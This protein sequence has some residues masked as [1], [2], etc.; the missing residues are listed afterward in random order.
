M[1]QRGRGIRSVIVM[2][3]DHNTFDA[4]A[5]ALAQTLPGVDLEKGMAL[6]RT[7]DAG[8]QATVWSGPRKL[9]KVYR[10]QL[11]AQ[12]LTMPARRRL[13]MPLGVFYTFY[14]VGLFGLFGVVFAVFVYKSTSQRIADAVVVAFF[15]IGAGFR[16]TRAHRRRLAAQADARAQW[17]AAHTA[18]ASAQVRA[19]AT[20]PNDH[21][22]VP[23]LGLAARLSRR[24]RKL[25]T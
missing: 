19:P 21:Q 22:P 1:K 14:Y 2:N 3:D 5:A 4:V 13:S 20:V 10:A 9:A 15:S 24:S 7:I 23:R 11:A 25:P 16:T 17:E 8:G 18:Q 12:G 6:A